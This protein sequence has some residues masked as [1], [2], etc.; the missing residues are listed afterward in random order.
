L[1]VL[2]RWVAPPLIAYILGH[3][4]LVRFLPQPAGNLLAIGMIVLAT[5]GSASNTMTLISRGDLALSVTVAAVNNIIAPFVQP[6]LITFLAVSFVGHTDTL[7]I[8]VELAEIVL[9]PIILGSIV[10]GIF[11]QQVKRINPCLGA[12]AVLCLSAVML[13]NISKGTSTL[14]KQLWIL[15]WMIG[16]CAVQAMAVL[17]VGYHVS[18]YFGFTMKQRV[19]ATFDVAVENAAL[20]TIIA[21]NHLGPLA[22]LPS[23]FYGKFQHMFGI[24]L[25]V[26]KFQ[27]MQELAEEEQPAVRVAVKE[28]TAMD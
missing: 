24:G 26:R 21:M 22:A 11:P 3:A 15:P 25:F 23:I 18:K 27:N 9:A 4:I 7:A 14:R 28:A 19:S 17:L 12:I 16:A 2:L 5:T 8:F 13:A 1:V 20:A 10:G 6:F